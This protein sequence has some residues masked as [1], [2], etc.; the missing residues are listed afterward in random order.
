M[1]KTI[2]RYETEKNDME[3]ERNLKTPFE[4]KG[5]WWL[6]DNPQ[7]Q[8]PGTFS[9]SST[10]TN[11]ELHGAFEQPREIFRGAPDRTIR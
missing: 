6:P 9:F 7:N 11:L 10:S 8:V 1:T 4:I 3:D 2:L 5:N